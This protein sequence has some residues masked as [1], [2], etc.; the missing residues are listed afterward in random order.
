M[1]PLG[2]RRTLPVGRGETSY[3][4]SLLSELP[5]KTPT[6]LGLGLR[7]GVHRQISA[8]AFPS[9]TAA[10]SNFFLRKQFVTEPEYLDYTCCPSSAQR[11]NKLTGDLPS[12]CQPVCSSTVEK[13]SSVELRLCEAGSPSSRLP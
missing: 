8:P 6:F 10:N 4:T 2:G 5:A 1:R 7:N 13:S 3:S 12:G 9:L 11:P